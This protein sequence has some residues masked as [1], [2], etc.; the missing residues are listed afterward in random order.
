MIARG[1]YGHFSTGALNCVSVGA[2]L[3]RSAMLS[4]Q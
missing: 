4:K 3:A 2:E 1:Q